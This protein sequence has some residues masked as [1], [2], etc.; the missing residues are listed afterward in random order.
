[1]IIALHVFQSQYV[2]L[3]TVSLEKGFNIWA[4]YGKLAI[5]LKNASKVKR[6]K[7]RNLI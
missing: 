2:D 5:L 7:E 1:M 4:Q 3:S 6:V